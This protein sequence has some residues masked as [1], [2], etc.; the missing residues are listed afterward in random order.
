VAF[1]STSLNP[2]Y[3]LA[4]EAGGAQKNTASL[5][6]GAV[7]ARA[8]F[9][10]VSS[11]ARGGKTMLVLGIHGG[12]NTLKQSEY[13]ISRFEQHNT[14]AVLLR[15]GEVV[16]AIEEERLNRI[17]H[18]NHTPLRAIA[19]CLEIAGVAMQD[20]DV[21]A[22]SCS[23]EQLDARVRSL[24]LQHPHIPRYEGFTD[25]VVRD[26]EAQFS[27]RVRARI[28]YCD[29][30]VAHAMSAFLCSG[31]R[32]SLVVTLDGAGDR[33]SGS[34]SVARPGSWDELC[35]FGEDHSLGEFYRS[36]IS[37][38][39]YSQFDEYK[40]MG[41]APYGDPERFRD[42][43]ASCF[44]LQPE[45]RYRMF[46]EAIRALERHFKPRRKGEPFEQI[47]RDGSAALQQALETI[48][49]HLL[50]HFRQ[51]T[52]MTNLSLAGGV[53]HNCSMNGRILSSGLFD[54]IFVQPAAHDA[55]TALGAAQHCHVRQRSG[56][57]TPSPMKHVYLGP[58]LPAA[59]PLEEILEQWRDFV[60]YTK[61]ADVCERAAQLIAEQNVIG[62][63]Q[64]RS[65]FGPRALGNRSILADPR[66]ARNKER[67]N[68][69]VKK[70]E[71]YRPFAPSVLHDDAH[72][73]FEIAKD[74]ALPFMTVVV[75]VRPEAREL[76][77]AVTHVDGTARIHTV[78]RETNPRYWRLIEAF[79]RRTGLPVLLN[80]SFN[81]HAEP[82]VD[83]VADALLC[84]L[85]TELDDLVIGDF[86]IRKRA[87]VSTPQLV[88]VLPSLPE[89]VILSMRT[90]TGGREWVL[91]T[92]N[93]APARRISQEM[94]H[95]LSRA[96]GRTSM[97]ELI[98]GRTAGPS[99]ELL[100][101]LESLVGARLVSI[102]PGPRRA[103]RTI[104]PA[105]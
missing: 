4:G 94:F 36:V 38:F 9:S 26:L 24:V 14:A 96:D 45:G 71:S 70:R 22:Y 7:T 81:N 68:A 15:D 16:A 41:L 74:I 1:S 34:V 73:Y 77:G 40:V 72:R 10:G 51:R 80:T 30:H 60:D 56:P 62:W 3:F 50:G 43:F 54:R 78:D 58:D 86:L 18:S 87:R 33:K 99:G 52:G 97:A 76:L 83:S 28:E 84:F 89:H 53:A 57:W 20:V 21:I 27:C 104:P 39:G 29:H 90:G 17:K 91:Q 44:E 8:I 66:P 61:E 64:G 37:H 65:E 98:S 13:F 63:V 79:G 47:H 95:V 67:I 46:P 55:G 88:H 85:S 42:L 92:P 5:R 2:I 49:L 48:V 103:E 82:I 100:V 32:E 12:L 59:A 101:E 31:F 25:L 35:T 23:K 6:A 93:G 105:R 102:A 69:I 11:S 19:A 75:N